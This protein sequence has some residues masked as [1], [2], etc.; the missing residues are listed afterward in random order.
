MVSEKNI[1]LSYPHYKSMGA[2][3]GHGGHLDLCTMTISLI[4][5]PLKHKAPHDV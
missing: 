3:Y 1:F 5:N 4:F 2:I